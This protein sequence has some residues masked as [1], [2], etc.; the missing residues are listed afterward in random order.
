MAP[1]LQL[2]IAVSTLSS[3]PSTAWGACCPGSAV[4]D[5]VPAS[6]VVMSSQPEHPFSWASFGRSVTVSV[7][8]GA[9]CRRAERRIKHILLVWTRSLPKCA[10]ICRVILGVSGGKYVAAQRCRQGSLKHGS[11]KR[12]Q[13]VSV[14]VSEL[15]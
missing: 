14:Y 12:P 7:K 9:E 15:T 8:L 2:R 10:N 3:S 1:E 4:K 5:A 13:A 11:R 6:S